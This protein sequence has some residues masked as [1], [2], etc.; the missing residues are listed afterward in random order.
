VA[1][2]SGRLASLTTVVAT[3]G[4]QGLGLSDIRPEGLEGLRLSQG[5]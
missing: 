1:S 5:S 4:L 2:N 3:S